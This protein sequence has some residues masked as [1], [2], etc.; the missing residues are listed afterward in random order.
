DERVAER[1]IL[2]LAER[3]T[4]HV[5]RHPSAGHIRP[6]TAQHQ[7]EGVSAVVAAVTYS[8]ERGHCD[9]AGTN[10]DFHAQP[11][12]EIVAQGALNITCDQGSLRRRN[13]VDRRHGMVGIHG[14]GGGGGEAEVDTITLPFLKV[15]SA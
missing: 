7:L 5:Y 11:T 15:V 14:E 1:R 8:T 12:A 10:R 9:R 13:G 6:V 4:R 3:P 2:E